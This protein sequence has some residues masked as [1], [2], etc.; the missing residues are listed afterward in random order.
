MTKI[1]QWKLTVSEAVIFVLL[2][3]TIVCSSPHKNTVHTDPLWFIYHYLSFNAHC[4]KEKPNYCSSNV[5]QEVE[6]KN[7]HLFY[8]DSKMKEEKQAYVSIFNL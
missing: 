5:L 7:E 4:N 3:I 2:Y 6:N 8:N 1:F